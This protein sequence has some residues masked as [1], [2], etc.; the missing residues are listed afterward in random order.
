L[1]SRRAI[2]VWRVKLISATVAT[3]GELPRQVGPAAHRH[4]QQPGERA[5]PEAGLQTVLD[6]LRR[7]G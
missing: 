5:K 1:I 6:V 3:R 7:I 4:G 2:L